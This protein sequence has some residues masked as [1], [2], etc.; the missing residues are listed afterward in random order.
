MKISNNGIEYR[1]INGGTSIMDKLPPK[2][3]TIKFHPQVG[4]WIEEREPLTVGGFKIYGNTP[5]RVNKIFRTFGLR[6]RNLGILLSGEKGMGKS[7]LMRHLASEAISRGLP[8]IVIDE[9]IPGLSGFISKIE[10]ECVVL[11]DEFEKVFMRGSGCDDSD[12]RDGIDCG[13]EQKQFLSLFDGMDAG[14]KL[15]VVA[16]NETRNISSFFLNRPGRFYYHFDFDF[17]TETETKEYALDNIKGD[18]SV[19]EKL[20]LISRFHN[21]SYD[22]LAA[23]IT[24]LNN[25]YG[26]KETLD[27]LN[28]DIS[29]NSKYYD[30]EMVVDGMTLKGSYWFGSQRGDSTIEY[31]SVNGGSGAGVICVVFDEDDVMLDQQT[32]TMYIPNT[33][34]KSISFERPFGRFTYDT[35]PIFTNIGATT[36]SIP[37]I[38]NNL[39]N[40][41]NAIP[42]AIDKL[43]LRPH[44]FE[45]TN[46]LEYLL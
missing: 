2:T 15:F 14:K 7:V 28:I 5:N 21:L 43:I 33:E 46:G 37:A 19:V 22:I 12:V 8:V 40:N 36:S 1:I 29:G 30:I 16:I 11:F 20:M 35:P 31:L 25:G 10:Q 26:L 27:D 23:I 45:F 17:L 24:E 4:T 41:P 9:K 44:N 39:N 32:G 18:K 42:V 13:G 34:I 6:N 38:G 3:Y